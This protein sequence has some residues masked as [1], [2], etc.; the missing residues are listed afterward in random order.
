MNND[1]RERFEALVDRSGE[2][3]LWL[4]AVNPSRG[5]GR[6][7]VD[8]RQI[9]AHRHAW[10]LEH[11]PLPSSARVFAC[12]S[13]PAC[14]RID[15]LRCQDDEPRPAG[16]GYRSS[17]AGGRA[18]KGGGSMQRIMA[19]TWKLS[20]TVDTGDGKQRRVHR[21]VEARNAKQATEELAF[22]AAEVRATPVV[23]APPELRKAVMDEAIRRFLHEHLRDERGR[24]QKTIDGYRALHDKW[25]APELGRRLVR[26]VVR[27]DFDRAF[28]K[29]RRAG[30]SSSRLNQAKSLYAPFF[31]WAINR[32]IVRVSPL[33]GFQLPTS[34]Y[35]SAERT[36]PEVEELCLLLREAV[37]TVPDVAPVLALGAVTGM[38][39]GELV[40]LRR[41]RIRWSDLRITVDSAID[42]QRVKSTK[43]RKERSL[44]LDDETIA[45]LARVCEQQDLLAAEVGALLVPDPFVFSLTVDG[46][47]PMPPDFV[48]KRAGVLKE[49]LGIEDKAAETVAREDLRAGPRPRRGHGRV[50]R[51]GR[52]QPATARGRRLRRARDCAHVLAIAGAPHLLTAR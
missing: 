25:F 32:A 16:A 4:G 29:M 20:I 21:T 52:R 6:L 1:Q 14:V 36:P 47:R 42:G 3:H 50:G 28:G 27:A 43:T 46:S 35:V 45:M 40:G 41:S 23:V 33:A 38:R 2:H 48:T 18:R 49:H 10:E 19:G 31:E 7:K 44:H 22:F 12:P 11:G 13:Q 26:D 15:H 34:T 9:T 37:L 5:T 24:E 30:L 8:G 17:R 39:R 51:P